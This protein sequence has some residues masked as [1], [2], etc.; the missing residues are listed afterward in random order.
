MMHCIKKILLLI[1]ITTSSL[2]FAQNQPR[3]LLIHTVPW[4]G[5]DGIHTFNFLK[6]LHDH[7]YHADILVT[8]NTPMHDL[9]K[10][11]KIPCYITPHQ[12]TTDNNSITKAVAKT[13]VDIC[14]KN[15]TSIVHANYRFQVASLEQAAHQVP[16][17]TVFTYHLPY[18]FPQKSLRNLDG[19]I[20]VDPQFKDKVIQSNKSLELGI[21][22]IAH[23]PPLFDADKFLTYKAPTDLRQDFFKKQF[24]IQ[25]NQDPL[26]VVVANMYT[27]LKHKNYPLLFEALRILKFHKKLPFH[28]VAAGDGPSRAKIKN[29]AIRKGLHDTISFVGFTNKIPELLNYADAV[30]LASSFEAFGII[31]LEAGLMK[32]PTIAARKTGAQQIV[33]DGS[34]GFLFEKDNAKDLALKIEKLIANKSFAQ[35]LGTNAYAH[36]IKNFLPE[37]TFSKIEVFYKKILAL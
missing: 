16:I 27:N 8:H 32:K 20:A 2:C 3:V 35:H 34:T 37:V 18:V 13:I 9:L 30:V 26:I 12:Q 31:L 23:I 21:K 14:K 19:F 10:R 6:M 28:V 29:L 5:G 15:K 7:G 1:F 17:K 22:H 25:L 36:I 4:M 24:N 11:N 33:I